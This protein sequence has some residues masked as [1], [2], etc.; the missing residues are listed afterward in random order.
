MKTLRGL[1]IVW[2]LRFTAGTLITEGHGAFGR[3]LVNAAK[4]ARLTGIVADEPAGLES[5][6]AGHGVRGHR[7]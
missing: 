2:L 6:L 3:L 4:L 7:P 1:P 5:Q